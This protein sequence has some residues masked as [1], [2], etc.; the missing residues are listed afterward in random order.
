MDYQAIFLNHIL[1]LIVIYLALVMPV[2]A[3]NT[4]VG[5]CIISNLVDNLLFYILG[6][7]LF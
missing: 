5:V 2:H 1:G 3:S 7:N 6:S 4:F